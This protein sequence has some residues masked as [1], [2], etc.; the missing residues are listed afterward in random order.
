MPASSIEL[1]EKVIE[2]LKL[3]KPIALCTIVDKI[4][5]GPR[6]VG[7]K[8]VVT[9]DG[10]V[11]GSIGGGG[12]ERILI[13]KAIES[14]REGKCRLITFSLGS[15]R[16]V[17]TGLI[18]GGSLTVFIDVIK[19]KPRLIIFGSGSIAKPLAEIAHRVGFEILIADDHE[20]TATRE[21]F[22]MASEI[23][24]EKPLSKVLGKLEIEASDFIAIVHGEVE[25]EFLILK[26]VLKKRP[27][28]V[29]LL[30]SKRKV[31]VL[32][33]RLLESGFTVKDL[34]ILHAPIGLDIGAET[35][36]EIAV[37]IVAELIKVLRGK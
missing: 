5:S 37:S 27:R 16:G 10:E 15:G 2:F 7:S 17:E 18:C 6:G 29:G 8:I 26:E 19:P 3:G 25:S 36:S 11:I 28:Y 9:S 24:I 35:P 13:D 14:I 34:D 30:G 21:R 31:S 12:F 32:K 20:D 4:G 33:K 22:P 1:F 23:I